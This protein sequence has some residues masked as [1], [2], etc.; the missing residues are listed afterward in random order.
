MRE[1]PGGAAVADEAAKLIGDADA[2]AAAAASWQTAAESG[3]Q[4]INTVKIAVREVDFAWQGASADAFV[5]YMGDVARR[6]DALEHSVGLCAVQLE[7]AAEALR[8]AKDRAYE[9]CRGYAAAVGDLRAKNPQATPEQILQ[10]VQPVAGEAISALREEADTANSA[11]ANA[12]IG[13]NGSLDALEKTFAGLQG[14]SGQSF[15]P[16][17]SRS[18][19]W[20]PTPQD[21][22]TDRSRSTE[23]AGTTSASSGGG[24][25]GVG[26]GGG[27][28]SSAGDVPA[29][30][31][32]VVEWI[33][34]A[35]KVI[36]SPEMA[37]VMRARGIDVSDL[38]LN[39]PKDI[40][41][42]W[43]IIHHES[44]GNPSAINNWDINAQNGVPSQGLMQTIPPTFDTHS[45]PGY[46]Q[47]LEPVD[48]IIA[49]ILYTYKR[50]G[51]LTHHP[52]IASLER[53]GGYQPY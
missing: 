3:R 17:E 44:G 31:A 13:I 47:I 9:I 46:K 2:V 49:G 25:G 28:V 45:L 32:Q 6:G 50:Y 30:R 43:T 10:S 12:A 21:V 29:P 36:R 24:G 35:L 20:T 7:N 37:G 41:R 19:D 52:G 8:H 38:D 11:L 14:P 51:D 18:L 15:V 34:E 48:N 4:Y 53:G 33:K 16:A 27:G 5:N 39:D 40:E 42:I 22:R 1:V 23:L 26:Y